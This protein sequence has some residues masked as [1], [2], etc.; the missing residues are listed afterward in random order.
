M[1]IA[2]D[3]SNK[4]IGFDSEL[5]EVTIFYKNDNKEKLLKKN[6]TLISEEIV[7]RVNIQLN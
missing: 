4:E 1:I 5:N 6:K 3:V 7:D 2:N